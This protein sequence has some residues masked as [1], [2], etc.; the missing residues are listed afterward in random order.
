VSVLACQTRPAPLLGQLLTEVFIKQL[1]WLIYGLQSSHPFNI[2][3][4]A[5]ADVDD[6][7]EA[8]KRSMFDRL[9]EPVPKAVPI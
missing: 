7:T 1:I 9:E 2:Y 5:P 8:L 6:I 4:L 3:C